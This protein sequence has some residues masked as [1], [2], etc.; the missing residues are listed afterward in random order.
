MIV[1]FHQEYQ[2]AKP[3]VD[4]AA[5]IQLVEHTARLIS[6]CCD[7]KK[8]LVPGSAEADSLK[9]IADYFSEWQTTAQHKGVEFGQVHSP[10]P[11]LLRCPDDGYF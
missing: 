6:L 7:E 4:L 8:R 1:C 2:K 9:R 11:I 3:A 5:T 10:E